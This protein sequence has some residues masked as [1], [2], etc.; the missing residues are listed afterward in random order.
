MRTWVQASYAVMCDRARR[1]CPLLQRVI[2]RLG[3]SA[4][5]YHR[6]LKVTRTIADLEGCERVRTAHAA[7]AIQYRTLDRAPR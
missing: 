1:C 5:A 2:D 4:R 7:E 6:M 3:L